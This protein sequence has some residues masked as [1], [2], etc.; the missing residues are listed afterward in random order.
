MIKGIEVNSKTGTCK[1]PYCGNEMG[2][3]PPFCEHL[4]SITIDAENKVFRF[5]E[6]E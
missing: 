2:T 3:T 5:T 6:G 1:C 4:Q